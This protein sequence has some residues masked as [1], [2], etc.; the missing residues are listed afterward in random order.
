M[1]FQL[2]TSYL[3][4]NGNAARSY[5]MNFYTFFFCIKHSVC[6]P[7]LISTQFYFHVVK[8]LYDTRALAQRLA[9][10]LRHVVLWCRYRKFKSHF[11]LHF[12]VLSTISVNGN[13]EYDCLWKVKAN[14]VEIQ[15]SN[16]LQ[17]LS[18]VNK[19]YPLLIL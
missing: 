6:G 12:H 1:D 18:F 13:G 2:S 8:L 19:P 16:T 9:H 14:S 3:S 15:H 11:L 7:P 5:S 4:S 17:K 10:V